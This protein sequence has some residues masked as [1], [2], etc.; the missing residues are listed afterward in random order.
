MPLHFN[1]KPLQQDV[2][3]QITEIYSYQGMNVKF[4]YTVNKKHFTQ[5]QDSSNGLLLTLNN[6]HIGFFQKKAGVISLKGIPSDKQKAILHE[7]AT[8]NII[9]PPK[10]GIGISLYIAFIC[11]ACLTIAFH[12]PHTSILFSL[13]ILGVVMSLLGVIM[14]NYIRPKNPTTDQLGTIAIV[15]HLIG[16]IGFLPTSFFSL[17]LIKALMR[18]RYLHFFI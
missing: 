9:K 2:A 17:P 4:S 11:L 18:K 5:W 6:K 7:I 10:L 14:L 1:I 15:L 3:E 13:S 12:I 8:L 16:T